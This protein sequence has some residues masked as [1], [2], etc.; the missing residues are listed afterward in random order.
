MAL[1]TAVLL[2]RWI[3]RPLA[4]FAEAANG[5]Y[6]TGKV[7]TVPETGPYEVAVLAR[8]FNDLQDRLARSVE[9]R[10]Q[11]LAAVSHDLKT[12][13]TRLRLRA[14]EIESNP[15]ARS[16]AQDL[17]EMERMIDQTLSYLR[18]DRSDETLRQVDLVAILETVTDDLIDQGAALTFAGPR[19]AVVTGRRL[20]LKRA[21]AN[22]VGNA[23]KYGGTARVT[24][25]ERSGR[26]IVLI[27]DDGEGI[28]PA[29]RER[30]LL[31]F[32]R[33]ESSRNNATGGFGLGLT[34]A[35]AVIDGHDGTLTFDTAPSGGLR[36]SVSLPG[37]SS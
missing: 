6:T 3:S 32:V 24:V 20:G 10:T 33:L 29:D 2:V 14:E 12:P 18:G 35:A 1:A 17:D 7:A 16:I 37:P 15:L 22:L 11:A 31:P 4:Q 36:V 23:V 27:D 30:V 21:F 13:I 26:V 19:S 28:A 8:A 9:D 5:F 34:I 25:A